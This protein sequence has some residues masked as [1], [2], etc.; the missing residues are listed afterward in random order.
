MVTE[1]IGK[2]IP[3]GLHVEHL[4]IIKKGILPI[5]HPIGSEKKPSGYKG[6]LPEVDF[7]SLFGQVF[8]T[9]PYGNVFPYFFDNI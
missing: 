9:Q 2:N 3:I 4:S 1:K 7:F 8:G 5:I 6:V